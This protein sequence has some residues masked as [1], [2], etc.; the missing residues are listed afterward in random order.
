DVAE[1]DHLSSFRIQSENIAL[2]TDRVDDTAGDSRRR[3]WS[4]V[5]LNPH[6]LIARIR[7][8]P[9]DPASGYVDGEDGIGLI[10]VAHG[11]SMVSD[12]GQRRVADADVDLPNLSRA[13]FGPDDCLGRDP[14]VIRSA[15]TWPV[16]AHYPGCGE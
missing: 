2:A 3:E 10:G 13:T 1:P 14:I 4:I 7:V 9:D 16:C 8:L 12:Y 6:L 15:E 11:V 5:I